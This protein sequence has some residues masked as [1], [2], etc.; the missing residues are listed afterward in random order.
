[1]QRLIQSV[2]SL[3]AN[4]HMFRSESIERLS[5]LKLEHKTIY[6]SA[7]DSTGRQYPTAVSKTK[8][9]SSKQESSQ[10][11]TELYTSVAMLSVKVDSLAYKLDA[12]LHK[13][14][15]IV[16]LNWWDRNKDKVYIGFAL[17]IVGW[18]VYKSRKK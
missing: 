17:I 6:L 4:V 9:E 16:E 18:I 11:D 3:K 5:N 15:Q 1:M 8:G 2:D 14:E 13:R 10:T 7:P 12:A